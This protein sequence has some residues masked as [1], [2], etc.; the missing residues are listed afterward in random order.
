MDIIK[1]WDYI[2]LLEKIKPED[3]F[4][5]SSVYEELGKYLLNNVEFSGDNDYGNLLFTLVGD[6]YEAGIKINIDNILEN[7]NSF[8]RE[9]F[10]DFDSIHGNSD[11]RIGFKSAFLDQYKIKYMEKITF[12]DVEKIFDSIDGDWNGDNAYQGLQIISKYCDRV[13]Q[14]ADND[15]IYSEDIGT[16]IEAGMT[17]DDFEK[18]A[19]LN[20][21]IHGDYYLALF[22]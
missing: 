15:I 9:N 2:G 12:E 5:I 20:W 19:K 13:I 17:K 4:F 3:Y 22:V 11:P 10:H 8:Y 21:M 16:L 18:L 14:G 6:I 7:Y 1:K